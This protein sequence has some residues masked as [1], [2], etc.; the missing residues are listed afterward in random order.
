MGGNG[1]VPAVIQ[2]APRWRWVALCLSALLAATAILFVGSTDDPVPPAR[3][4]RE[5][6]AALGLAW[7]A[8][9]RSGFISLLHDTSRLKKALRES[10][11]ADPW[12]LW[13]GG[14]GSIDA[15]LTAR[16]VSERIAPGQATSTLRVE[17]MVPGPDGLTA[18]PVDVLFIS[19][20][21]RYLFFDAGL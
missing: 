11:G 12:S 7:R 15:F 19:V 9:D 16:V 13:A 3:S 18:V 2:L 21:G 1:K 4:P 20:H 10:P 6:F 8:R 5:T 14:T 17:V